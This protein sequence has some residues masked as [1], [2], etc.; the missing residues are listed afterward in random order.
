LLPSL[1]RDIPDISFFA[2]GKAR[3]LDV[4]RLPG[5]R[6]HFSPIRHGSR[7]LL[8]DR[9]LALAFHRSL[10]S[11]DTVVFPKLPPLPVFA[12]LLDLVKR[13]GAAPRFIFVT[14]YR[15]SE[16]WRRDMP[17]LYRDNLDCIIAQDESFCAEL[18]A[19]GYRGRLEVIP[20]VPPAVPAKLRELPERSGRPARLGYLGRLEP[21]KNLQYLMALLTHLSR[22]Y[23]LHIFGDGSQRSS[24]E[25]LADSLGVNAVFHGPV[26][27]DAKWRAI[28]SCDLFLN[29]S[30]SEGQCLV[31]L[32]VLSRGRPFLATPVGALPGMLR[33]GSL[34][35]LLPLDDARA[36]ADILS[37]VLDEQSRG[38]WSPDR[39]AGLYG[40][41]FP[42]NESI[43][44]YLSVLTR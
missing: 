14:P 42:R 31:A 2:W 13:G 16:M 22:P 34:G 24:L 19:Y 5:V 11:I 10:P 7:F 9:V 30:T 3:A 20:Y 41:R 28:E 25:T 8:P 1:L 18:L 6:L 15:P 38:G 36:A 43:G 29:S 37:R 21:Q 26:V 33:D 12:L 27:G 40:E 44:R 32:E 4:V 23:E 39:I 35:V 17:A